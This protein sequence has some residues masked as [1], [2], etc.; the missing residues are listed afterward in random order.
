MPTIFAGLA[1]ML[2]YSGS[3]VATRHAM[4]AG[5]GPLDVMM[6]RYLLGGLACAA[7][8]ARIG[9]GGLSWT[10]VAVLT[11]LGGLPYYGMQVVGVGLSSASHAA[12]L[13][14]GG[15]VVF[16]T[17]LGWLVLRDKPGR[18]ALA[19][20]PL[21]LGGL[22]LIAGTGFDSAALLGDGMLLISGLQWA[23]YGTLLRSWGVSGLRSA[24]MISAFSLP[25]VPVHLLVFGW[26]GLAAAPEEALFQALYQG[27]GV[28]L[29]ANA[30]YSHCY[31]VM[32]PG[33]AAIF[34][35][36]VPVLGTLLAALVL[37]EALSAGQFLGMALVVSGMLLAGLWRRPAW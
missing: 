34:P 6:L 31:A 36:L 8:L 16:A 27:L 37:A 29:L 13:N 23:L 17:L 19:A 28:G 1:A 32:G 24:C 15:T 4:M 30:L 5:L 12:M 20:L 25:Y 3:F 26:G 33:R 7:V 10:R 35:P 22:V 2:L 18:G 21:L 14:P 9:L 11:L